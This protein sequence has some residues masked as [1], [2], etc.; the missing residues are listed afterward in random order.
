MSVSILPP[1]VFHKIESL[2]QK[3]V[4]ARQAGQGTSGICQS[5]VYRCTA[6]PGFLGECWECE[7]GSHACIA[8]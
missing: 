4:L 5:Q 7:F 1:P 2:S 6:T 3:P 8:G